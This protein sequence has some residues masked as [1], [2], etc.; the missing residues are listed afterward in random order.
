M[1]T[2]NNNGRELTYCENYAYLISL[3][4]KVD[5]TNDTNLDIKTKAATK[6]FFFEEIAK[7]ATY[8]ASLLDKQLK[9]IN[10][11]SLKGK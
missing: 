3:L 6:Q 9:L 11:T 4:D 8:Q 7:A 2:Q 5:K 1:T 10:N